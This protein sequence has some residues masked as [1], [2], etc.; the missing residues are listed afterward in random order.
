MELAGDER[1]GVLLVLFRYHFRLIEVDGRASG[2]IV[3][4]ALLLP[5]DVVVADAEDV[6]VVDLKNVSSSNNS[7]V[8]KPAPRPC[9]CA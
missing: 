1:E 9:S 2:W 7:S 3:Y 4:G 5:V 8:A 6:V